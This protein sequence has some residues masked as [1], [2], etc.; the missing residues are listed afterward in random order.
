MIF[1]N[2]LYI[3]QSEHY[4]RMRFLKFAYKNIFSWHKLSDRGDIDWTL[5]AKI[6][7]GFSSILFFLSCFLLYWVFFIMI[8]FILFFYYD[9]LFTD[10]NPIISTYNIL[11]IVSIIFSCI[12]SVLLFPV[13]LILS[14]FFLAPV[15]NWKKQKIFLQAEKILEKLKKGNSDNS[16]T[17]TRLVSGNLQVIG[18][19]GSFGKT[20]LKNILTKILETQFSIMTIPGNINTDLGVANYIIAHQQELQNIDFLIVEMGAFTTGEIQS[21]C[22]VVHPEYSFLTAIAPVH[23]ERFGSIENT[24]QA[25]FELPHSTS[26]ISYLNSKNKNIQKFFPKLWKNS[27]GRYYISLDENLSTGVCNTP[28][29]ENSEISEIKNITFLPE[30]S[31]ISFEYKNQ[32]FSTKLISDYIFEF[33]EIIFPFAEHLEISPENIQKGIEKIE[34]TPHR[35]EV[36]KNKN[37][38]VT[39]IDDSY[40]GN[41]SGFVAGIDTLS[42]ASGRKIVLTPGIVELGEISEKV[43]LD[44]AKIYKEKVDFLLLIENSNTKIIQKFLD[45]QKFLNYKM[46][47]DVHKAH[48]DLSTI[49]KKGDTILFQNDLSDNY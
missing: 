14:D 18:I 29:R 2:L 27:V 15:L 30:F 49:L 20:S 6:L 11:E 39:V 5:R 16:S 1:S 4:D 28:L 32:K 21:I 22:D 31:G 13:F 33:L 8:I 45:N 10:I 34:Y 19:T 25:K 40:N 46:Y 24:A 23:L 7:M 36:I 48:A 47:S 44:L 38:G 43:H 35:L 41:F 42:R 37:T 17:S 9:G 3:F 12:S 26:K